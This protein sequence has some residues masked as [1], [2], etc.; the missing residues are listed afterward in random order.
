MNNT[1]LADC[2]IWSEDPTQV[3]LLLIMNF[4]LWAVFIL[5]CFQIKSMACAICIL[6]LSNSWELL[7]FFIQTFT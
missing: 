7:R 1:K 3:S 2:K 5:G 4:K 6:C